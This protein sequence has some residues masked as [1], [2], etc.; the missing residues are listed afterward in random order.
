MRQLQKI[1]TKSTI[2]ISD[3]PPRVIFMEKGCQTFILTTRT[4]CES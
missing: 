3:I 1:P 4:N 2:D